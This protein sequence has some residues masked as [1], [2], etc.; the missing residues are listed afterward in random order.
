M[1]NCGEE[2]DNSCYRCRVKF[3]TL[4]IQLPIGLRNFLCHLI[5]L[6]KSRKN[7]LYSKHDVSHLRRTRDADK[8]RYAGNIRIAT[9]EAP[10]RWRLRSDR[11]TVHSWLEKAT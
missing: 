1:E 3:E 9:S 2:E 5:N 7:A 10:S 4:N 8:R 11:Y 6:V